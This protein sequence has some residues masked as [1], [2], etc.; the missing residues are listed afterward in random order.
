MSILKIEVEGGDGAGKSTGL[1]YLIE[2]AQKLG[3][4]VVE[5]REVGNPHVSVAVELRKLVLDP[6]NNM[7]GESMEFIFS[8]MRIESDK[9]FKNL[10]NST[11]SVDL[12]ISDRGYFS[13][14]AYTDHNVSEEFTQKLYVDLMEN[15]TLLPDVV[16][17]FSVDANTALK[18]RIKR[19]AEIDAIEMKGVDF[20][21]KVRGSFEKYIKAYFDSIDIYTVDANQ[22]ISGVRDQLDQI[23]TTITDKY[24]LPKNGRHTNID[25]WNIGV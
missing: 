2:Q 8:A 16:I 25:N 14:L 5:T 20:Q 18:R 6:K 10:Q 22:D 15:I 21:E 11:N 24:G 19:G 23:L 7:S 9:W 12:V 17:Y 4:V 13:H 3:L 1:K